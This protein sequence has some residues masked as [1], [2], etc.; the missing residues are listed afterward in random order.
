MGL[1][2]SHFA[3]MLATPLK[4]D[5][6]EGS[7]ISS[8]PA[9]TEQIP[10]TATLV[11]VPQKHKFCEDQGLALYPPTKISHPHE[12]SPISGD[13]A[14]TMQIPCTATLVEVPQKCKFCED[15]DLA[16]DPPTKMSRG[17]SLVFQ[18]SSVSIQQIHHV[19]LVTPSLKH[20]NSEAHDLV[21]GCPAKVP[22]TASSISLR[23]HSCFIWQLPNEL[24]GHITT[25]LPLNS[26]L[27]L[28]QMTTDYH[29]YALRTFFKLLTAES[30]ILVPAGMHPRVRMQ[31]I[32]LPWLV[33]GGRA[34]DLPW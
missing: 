7:P 28:T 33:V 21:L 32:E 29:L 8:D 22:H 2:Q 19:P 14:P 4:G 5:A 20:K 23:G 15:Q 9:P 31:G 34:A 16:L 25:F 10:H 3:G 24:L 26:L 6:H 27:A 13:P 17:T 30:F 11:E 1:I 18:T 12:G